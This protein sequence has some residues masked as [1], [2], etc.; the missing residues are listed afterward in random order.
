MDLVRHIFL[1][2]LI[3]LCSFLLAEPVANVAASIFHDTGFY[4]YFSFVLGFPVVFIFL[5]VS[6]FFGFGGDRKYLW[7]GI[8]IL[9]ALV[10]ILYFQFQSSSLDFIYLSVTSGV[11]GL[12]VGYAI[13]KA[14]S[15]LLKK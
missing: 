2:T 7:L 12:I 8:L 14:K 13:L 15:L 10:Y 11:L 5:S 6:I 9:F 3:L 1:V 4:G